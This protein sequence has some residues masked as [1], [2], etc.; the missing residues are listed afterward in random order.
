M[1]PVKTDLR[2]MIGKE[3]GKTVIVRLEEWL[4]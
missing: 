4:N 1:L 3:A 2:K